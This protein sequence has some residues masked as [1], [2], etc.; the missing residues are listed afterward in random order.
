MGVSKLATRFTGASK[1]SKQCSVIKAEMSLEIPPNSESS[2]NIIAF[3]VFLTELK[4][5]LVSNG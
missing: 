5:V 4:I 3:P 2:C 1:Y